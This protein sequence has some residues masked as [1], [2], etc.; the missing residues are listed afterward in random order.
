VYVK[1]FS[2]NPFVDPANVAID[3][4]QNFVPVSSLPEIFAVIHVCN[5]DNVACAVHDDDESNRDSYV[6]DVIRAVKYSDMDD[7][8]PRNDFSSSVY[9]SELKRNVALR[10]AIVDDAVNGTHLAAAN[11]VVKFEETYGRVASANL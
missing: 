11:S 1:V 2:A 6:T 5:A 3:R 4:I 9:K 7:I 10:V 8:K